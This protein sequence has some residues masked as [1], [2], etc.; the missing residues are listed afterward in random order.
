VPKIV[1]ASAA[2]EK[3]KTKGAAKSGNN[4]MFVDL[5]IDSPPQKTSAC[6]R[7]RRWH[8]H[9][10]RQYWSDFFPLHTYTLG[11][12]ETDATSNSQIRNN[13]AGMCF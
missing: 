8:G 7:D 10:V 5:A 11:L 12:P 2:A 3:Y 4:N 9:R 1:A 6:L 13:M